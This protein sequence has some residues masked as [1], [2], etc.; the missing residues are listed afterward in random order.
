MSL[1]DGY[2]ALREKLQIQITNWDRSR[3]LLASFVRSKVRT[4]HLFSY[5]ERHSV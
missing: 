1:C 5:S 4:C 2:M 3:L